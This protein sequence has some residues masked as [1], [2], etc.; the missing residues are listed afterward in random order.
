MRDNGGELFELASSAT[1]QINHRLGRLPVGWMLLD[2]QADSG[3]SAPLYRI[4][5]DKT[6]IT[7][8]NP[9]GS[10]VRFRIWVW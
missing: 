6:I 8:G 1:Y 4:S 3:P 9:A 5:W 2:Y 7:I 10:T